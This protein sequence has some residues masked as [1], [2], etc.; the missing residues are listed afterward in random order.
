M[1]SFHPNLLFRFRSLDS[2]VKEFTK[3]TITKSELFFAPPA[4]LNDPYDCQVTLDTSG[5]DEEWRRHFLDAL[6][7]PGKRKLSVS[8]RLLLANRIVKQKRH[9]KLNGKEFSRITEHFGIVCFSAIMNNLLMWAHYANNHRGIC[10][11]YDPDRDCH[12]VI[13]NPLEVR[14][15]KEYPKVRVVDLKKGGD[16]IVS[17]LLLTKS[18]DWKYEQEYRVIFPYGA[19]NVKQHHPAALVGVI[20]GAR[21]SVE[22]KI[23][24]ETWVREHPYRP[25]LHYAELNHTSYGV[26]FD[27]KKSK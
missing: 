19:K 9:E 15:Q 3:S 10:L 26:S 1:N 5:T 4:G 22:D 17:N 13:A 14:Y 20:V 23:E 25:L 2:S 6:K 12:G 11:V 8:E 27:P 18:E 7:A 21:C 24:V 16:P